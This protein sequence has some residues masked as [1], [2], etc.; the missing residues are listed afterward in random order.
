MS[1]RLMRVGLII[2]PIAGMGGSV[3][4]KGSDGGLAARARELG[5]QPEAA[6]RVAA[7]LLELL[8]LGCPVAWYTAAG[9]MGEDALIAA[10]TPPADVTVLHQAAA[11]TRYQDTQH[12]ATRM[13]DTR[14]DLLLFAGGDGTARD[15]LAV[16][17]DRIPILGIPAGV[18][19]HSA[20]FALTP[21]TAGNA[22]RRFLEAGAPMR[23]CASGA[24]MDREFLANGEPASSPSLHGYLTTLKMPSLVQAAKSASGGGG[25][26]AVLA[27]LP[28]LAAQLREFD[29]LLLG[30]GATLKALKQELGFDGSLLGVDVFARGRCL[31]RD[32]REDQI[33]ALLQERDVGSASGHT[34]GLALGVIGGQGF[35]L[36]R[37]NQQLSARVLKAVPRENIRIVAAA[38]KLAMLSASTLFVDTG[39]DAVDDE[40]SGYLP[41]VTGVRRSTL[42][43]IA[44]SG[45]LERSDVAK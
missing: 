37:G 39:D 7:A 13:L 3:G 43:R 41:V 9:S 28:G 8:R 6:N 38:D 14:L 45:E 25:D 17:D 31:V 33:W 36:G 20:V 1:E 30:P 22:A 5:A 26:G 44:T 40:L 19:M 16:V 27:A 2:N 23:F 21:R 24:V 18:K 4:L 34:I 12:V 32:A 35:L 11:P 10:G 42:C 29:V 15:I